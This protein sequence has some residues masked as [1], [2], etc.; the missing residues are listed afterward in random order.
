MGSNIALIEPTVPDAAKKQCDLMTHLDSI[1]SLATISSVSSPNCCDKLSH[2]VPPLSN[3]KRGI[4]F[5]E[6]MYD[7]FSL[8]SRIGR[9]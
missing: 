4:V 7:E 9:T 8:S 1:G 3:S 2:D 5:D 6:V